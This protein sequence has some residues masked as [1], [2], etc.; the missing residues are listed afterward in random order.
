LQWLLDSGTISAMRRTKSLSD[1]YIFPGFRPLR[2]PKG[3]FGD[4]YARIVVLKRRGKKLA[5]GRVVR[6]VG[7]TTTMSCG[8]SVTCPVA[9]SASTWNWNCV[10]SGAGAAAP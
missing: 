1:G 10:V 9:L 4:R 8:E 6:S 5:A 7:P 3:L 2:R